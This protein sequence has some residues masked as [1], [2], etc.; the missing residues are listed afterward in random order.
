MT[1]ATIKN[2]RSKKKSEV[3]AKNYPDYKVLLHNDDGVYAGL[4]VELLQKHIPRMNETKAVSIM[5]EAHR[6]GTGLVITCHQELAEMYQ[7]ILR[8]E[9]LTVSIEP[10]I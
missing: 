3:K 10:I 5:M 6:T 2:P 7:D 4:V 8:G 1:S 9:S